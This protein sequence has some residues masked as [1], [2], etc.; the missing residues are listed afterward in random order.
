[1]P[2]TTFRFD[3]ELEYD[4]LASELVH[5]DATRFDQKSDFANS[6][7]EFGRTKSLYS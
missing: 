1:M 5:E 7:Q 6:C 2:L 4:F 3:Y